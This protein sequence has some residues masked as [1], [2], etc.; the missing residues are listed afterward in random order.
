MAMSEWCRRAYHINSIVATPYY[1]HYA[2]AV[3]IILYLYYFELVPYY[4]L[5]IDCD[6]YIILFCYSFTWFHV[7]PLYRARRAHRRHDS[8]AGGRHLFPSLLFLTSTRN[9]TRN[10]NVPTGAYRNVPLPSTPCYICTSISLCIT[11]CLT[12]AI[13]CCVNYLS[14]TK[15]S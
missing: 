2:R 11:F 12:Y 10:P 1:R 6:F 14:L 4:S 8:R 13:P 7:T 15:T 3:F 9:V 5:Y